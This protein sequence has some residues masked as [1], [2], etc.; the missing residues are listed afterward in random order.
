M[1]QINQLL[2][3][4]RTGNYSEQ[5]LNDLL[6]VMQKPLH[7][8]I[9][10]ISMNFHWNEC[11]D[12][13]LGDDQRFQQILNEIHHNINLKSTKVIKPSWTKKLY[14]GLSRVAA[15]II[16]PLII[17]LIISISHQQSNLAV[18]QNTIN[19]PLGASSQFDLPDGTHIW[20]NSGSKLTYPMSFENQSNRIVALNGEGFF[21]VKKNKKCPFIVKMNGMDIKVTGTTFNARAYSDE[22]NVTVALV[23]G[24]VLLGKQTFENNFDVSNGLHPMEVA[25]LNKIS[26]QFIITPKSDLTKYTAWTQGIT[27]FDNDPILNVTEKLQKLYNVRVLIPDKELLQYRLTA[28]FVNEPLDRALKI[29]SLSSPINYHIINGK[30]NAN[31][32][33]GQRTLILK[34]TNKFR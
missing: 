2:K 5:E 24:S 15:I 28:T 20:L 7:N 23:E 17:A 4:F 29:I 12:N 9:V 33:Y 27:I 11:A 31:G 22:P 32:T 6:D 25:V 18:L 10:N 16:I 30:Q 13:A 14:V 3:N 1:I 19:V 21:K 26:K 8:D 34:K